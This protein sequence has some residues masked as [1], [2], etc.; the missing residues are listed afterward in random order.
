MGWQLPRQILTKSKKFQNSK[1]FWGE[2]LIYIKE[3]F[4]HK[5]I[6]ILKFFGLRQN[7]TWQLPAQI[8]KG[9]SKFWI[10]YT[11]KNCL[12]CGTN[13]IFKKPWANNVLNFSKKF[14]FKKFPRRI[15]FWK[16][17]I[18]P[19]FFTF[20]D[21][22]NWTRFVATTKKKLLVKIWW[23][24]SNK[25]VLTIGSN[26]SQILNKWDYSGNQNWTGLKLDQSATHRTP[27]LSI[28][29]PFLRFLTDQNKNACSNLH[30]S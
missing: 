1:F 24:F 17:R 18:A 14:G 13:F 30:I 12:N 3:E 29:G 27:N 16:S 19:I 21:M 15:F 10:C 25:V 4:S 26:M 22:K 2:F 8:K 20:Q 9:C 7:L 5:K 23:S 6:W 11:F 28:S